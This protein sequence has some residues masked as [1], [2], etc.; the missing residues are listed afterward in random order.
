MALAAVLR[1]GRRGSRLRHR[2]AACQLPLPCMPSCWL[3]RR[4]VPGCA[5]VDHAV[6]SWAGRETPPDGGGVV[7]DAGPVGISSQRS[8]VADHQQA[9]PRTAATA[10]GRTLRN[11]H[12]GPAAAAGTQ[13]CISR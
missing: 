2:S 3:S 4:P 5:C 8:S 6:S 12:V 7:D 13:S 9:G 11:S 1:W 10:D